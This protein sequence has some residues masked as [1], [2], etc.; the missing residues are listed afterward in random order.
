MNSYHDIIKDDLDRLEDFMVDRKIEQGN[1]W[2]NDTT[3]SECGCCAG[4][5]IARCFLSSYSE[6][7]H[8]DFVLEFMPRVPEWR[9]SF[10]DYVSKNTPADFLDI[11]EEELELNDDL[12][13]EWLREGG[14]NEGLLA[15]SYR[16]G[17]E[18]LVHTILGLDRHEEQR[19]HQML[20]LFAYKDTEMRDPW[21]HLGWCTN[22]ISLPIRL[23]AIAWDYFDQNIR[24][25]MNDV[26]QDIHDMDSYMQKVADGD[27]DDELN[28]QFALNGVDVKME[29]WLSSMRA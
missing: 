14:K 8:A 28:K 17:I 12:V 11:D 4:A 3:D 19:F 16:Q 23:A 1:P 10:H 27:M 7:L 22:D 5:H 24:Y 20:S 6:G 15:M 29:D 26:T 18:Y 21:S 9:R 13:L 25:K 2:S